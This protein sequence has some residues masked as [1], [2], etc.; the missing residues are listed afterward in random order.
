MFL[1]VGWLRR[2]ISEPLIDNALSFITP[3]AAYVA[4]ERI[5]GS[6]VI[7]VVVAGILLAHQAPIHRRQ[8]LPASP[9]GTTG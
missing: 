9:S 3:F 2:N 5:H 1:I 8:L 7:A 6:G 4:A